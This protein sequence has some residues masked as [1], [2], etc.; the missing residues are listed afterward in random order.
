MNGKEPGEATAAGKNAREPHEFEY[1]ETV[2]ITEIEPC[3]IPSKFYD[4]VT[5]ANIES[6]YSFS[7]AYSAKSIGLFE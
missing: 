3:W 2:I 5:P 7:G 4:Q 6:A 1:R